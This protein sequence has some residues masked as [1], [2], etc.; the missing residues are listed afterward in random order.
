MKK[1]ITVT[2]MIFALTAC[3]QSIPDNWNG[4]E[5]DVTTSALITDVSDISK[6]GEPPAEN[7]LTWA[8]EPTLDFDKIV[9]VAE[10]KPYGEYVAYVGETPMYIINP[11]SGETTPADEPFGAVTD[12]KSYGYITAES[13]FY[14]HGQADYFP[15]SDE[16]VAECSADTVINVYELIKNENGDVVY[17]EAGNSAVYYNGK[18]ISDFRYDDVISGREIAF[19]K[20]EGKYAVMNKGG[21]LVTE[22]I[23]ND[24]SGIARGYA[25]VCNMDGMWGLLDYNG[26]EIAP[27]IFE[28]IEGIDEN[29]V[30]AKYN[31]KYGILTVPKAAQPDYGG[32]T[33]VVEP[34][35]GYS[36]IV[37]IPVSP[38]NGYLGYGGR[39]EMCIVDPRTGDVLSEAYP[40]GGFRGWRSY[41]YCEED[42]KLVVY[43]QYELTEMD[44]AEAVEESR[45]AILEIYEVVI[46]DN[47]YGHYNTKEGRKCA[48]FYNGEY[49][50]GFDYDLVMSGGEIAFVGIDSDNAGNF[51][52]A[53]MNNKGELITD[54]V[55]T[56]AS[57]VAAGYAAVCNEAGMW[58]L[59]DYN[60]NEI[61]PFV[62]EHIEGI[63][64]NTV[65]AKYN[66]KYGILA[67]NN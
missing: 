30:F 15:V 62:F 36:G 10:D 25:A 35:L 5:T 67:V 65:F 47:E 64:E 2:A 16:E 49:I 19:V 8:V 50:S 22:N 14:S 54:F 38:Y 34:V 24:A 11:K 28:H 55:Y 4:A 43:D 57:E 26:N 20:F 32:F 27:F 66:G 46:A 59:I 40:T 13:V 33:W 6:V 58:G 42:G 61:A 41:G 51:K 31:G 56:N 48:A 63:D 29:T 45:G 44:E 3:S 7:V 37:Y 1:L 52:Y 17:D 53:V 18:F 39:Y 60:G 12:G 21:W 9:C 23:Y